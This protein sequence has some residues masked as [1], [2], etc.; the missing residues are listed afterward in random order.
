MRHVAKVIAK[1]PNE[2]IHIKLG[3]L[4]NSMISVTINLQDKIYL[5]ES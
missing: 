2:T 5:P 3:F 1:Q 4:V